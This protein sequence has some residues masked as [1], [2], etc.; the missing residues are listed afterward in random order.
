MLTNSSWSA[1]LASS[2]PGLLLLPREWNADGTKPAILYCHGYEASEMVLG[3]DPV[4][5]VL[6]ALT[7]QGFAV[8][9]CYLGGDTWGNDSCM[10]RMDAAVTYLTGTVKA[11][12]NKLGIIG[13]SMGHVAAVN[14]A[15]RHPTTVKWILSMMGICD[16]NDLYLNH[17]GTGF[18][19][20]IDAA[21]PSGTSQW[22]VSNYNPIVNAAAKMA[23]IPW[24]GWYGQLDT[25][26]LPALAQSF[27]GAFGGDLHMIADGDHSW[28]QVSEWDI[29]G[30]A[31]FCSEYFKR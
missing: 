31:R 11:N 30:I 27:A 8:L 20:S 5:P 3:S 22:N 1:T 21:Y 17:A 29:P 14:Y 2:E 15:I 18:K 16:L 10:T 24:Q 4:F 7:D 25:T 6:N 13:R 19:A 9:S 28:G 26:S 23:K 12:P